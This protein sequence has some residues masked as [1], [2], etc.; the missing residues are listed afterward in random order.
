MTPKQ[1]IQE[2]YSDAYF[3]KDNSCKYSGEELEWYLQGVE[4]FWEEYDIDVMS[5]LN[6]G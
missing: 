4:L 6:G 5:E 1:V 3:G 2:G